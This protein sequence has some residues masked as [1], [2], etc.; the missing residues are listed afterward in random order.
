MTSITKNV[1]IE[2]LDNIANK[3]NKYNNTYHKTIKMKSIYSKWITYVDFDVENNDKD[4]KFKNI[5]IV[6]FLM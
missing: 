1:Y 2:K 4:P 5:K 6:T 3:Y